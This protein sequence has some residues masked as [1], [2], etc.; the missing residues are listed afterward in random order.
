MYNLKSFFKNSGLYAMLLLVIVSTVNCKKKSDTPTPKVTVAFQ[1]KKYIIDAYIAN[2]APDMQVNYGSDPKIYT[3]AW[4]YSGTPVEIK[5]LLKFDYSSIPSSATIKSA[6]LTLYADTTDQFP[7]GSTFNTGNFGSAD[8][9][10]IS[11]VT[12]TWSESTVTWASKPTNSILNQV[13]LKP[14]S[15]SDSLYVDVTQLVIDQHVNGN[16]GFQLDLLNYTPYT[17]LAFYSSECTNY[18]KLIPK[19][20]IQY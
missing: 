9:S 19:L 11:N 18:P 1:D 5:T 13:K 6:Y 20:V 17:R 15:T 12:S 14:L 2:Y 7:Y 16:Y 10:V 8:S 4:T 3:S